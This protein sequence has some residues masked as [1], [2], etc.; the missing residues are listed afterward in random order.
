MSDWVA[1]LRKRGH[2]V[3][4]TNDRD[5]RSY[6]ISLTDEGR[7]VQCETNSYFE[8][9]NRLFLKGLGTTE[10]EMRTHVQQM[11]HAAQTATATI[12]CELLKGT[13]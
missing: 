10:R 8:R 11:I 5:R 9:V 13:A 4:V 6:L 7:R 12:D 2:L 3:S 1:L